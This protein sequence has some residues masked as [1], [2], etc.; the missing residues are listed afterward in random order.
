MA[1]IV[2]TDIA[3]SELD[4]IAEYIALDKPAAACQL[5]AKVFKAV[6]RLEEFPASGRYPPELG[7]GRYREV[8]VG[9]CRIFYRCEEEKVLI[10]YVMR[11]EQLL[12]TSVVE[13]WK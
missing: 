11:G 6:D 4:E 12:K 13:G 8:V 3:L 7:V 1:E 5:I 9:P 10:L 2:W